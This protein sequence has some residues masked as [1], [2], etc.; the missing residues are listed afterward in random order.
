MIGAES[1]QR[2]GIDMSETARIADQ[3]LKMFEGGAWHG[4]SVLEVLAN[5]N[6]E[7]AASYPIPSAHNIWELVLHLIATQDLLLRRIRGEVAGLK[8]ED[9]WLPVPPVSEPAWAE[10]VERLK[11]QE[12]ELRQA[13]GDFPDERL[14]VV[15]MTG[16][17]TAYNNFHGHVQHNAYHAGQIALLKKAQRA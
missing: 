17:S 8:T 5:V 7:M 2:R 15:L 13:I 9:F 11:R 6:A 1:R 12:T 14:D 4:P 16:G 10:T 3:A